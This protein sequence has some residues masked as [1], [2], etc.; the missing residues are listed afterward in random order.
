MEKPKKFPISEVTHMEEGVSITSIA[1]MF[2]YNQACD[3]WEKYHEW[4]IKTHCVKKK[5]LPTVEE[6]ARYIRKS[7][8]YDYIDCE[9]GGEIAEKHTYL[10]AQTLA[11][12]IGKKG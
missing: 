3:K 11:K 1:E 4:Y 2:G 9:E 5:D 12:R 7:E 6:I 8:F 10:L